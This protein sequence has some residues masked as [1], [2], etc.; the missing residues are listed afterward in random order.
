MRVAQSVPGYRGEESWEDP[1][2]GL[3][4]NV[5]HWDS[6]EALQQ[7]IEHPAHQVARQQQG[8]WLAGCQVTIS[9]VLK[10]YGDGGLAHPLA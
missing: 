9:Q 8:Q 4:C 10:S 7:L 5:Y 6:L 3:V 2:S 1:A